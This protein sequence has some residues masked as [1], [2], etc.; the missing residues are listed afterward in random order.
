LPAALKE[1]ARRSALTAEVNCQALTRY[2]SRLEAA[3]YFCCLEAL[4]NAAKHAGQR[5]RATISLADQDGVLRFAVA[6]DG[7]G[8]D[9]PSATASAG[10]Q[11]MADRIGALGG[12][13]RVD[14]TPGR[15]TTV[16]GLVALRM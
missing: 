12:E 4:Q 7:A 10:L 3:V 14:S 1:A 16:S 13:L 11:N 6:D 5:A 2:P 9:I 8:F 15:G